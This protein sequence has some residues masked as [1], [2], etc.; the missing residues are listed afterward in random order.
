MVSGDCV[1]KGRV[2]TSYTCKGIL[3]Y[4][5]SNKMI[6]ILYKMYYVFPILSFFFEYLFLICDNMGLTQSR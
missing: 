4:T 6:D 2:V 1:Y 3:N 5:N